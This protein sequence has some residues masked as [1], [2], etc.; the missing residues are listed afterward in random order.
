MNYIKR[1]LEL[2][3]TPCPLCYQGE[4]QVLDNLHLKCY[5]CGVEMTITKE[6]IDRSNEK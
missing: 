2:E 5:K 1:L 6:N 3:H 4:F